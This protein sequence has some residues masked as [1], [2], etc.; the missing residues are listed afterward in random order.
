MSLGNP[1]ENVMSG[2]Q[3]HSTPLSQPDSENKNDTLAAAGLLQ[4]PTPRSL[5]SSKFWK[6]KD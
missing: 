4:A 6:P 1:C 3:R 5:V 2:H